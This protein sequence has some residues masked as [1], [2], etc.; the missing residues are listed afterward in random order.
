MMREMSD[1]IQDLAMA[2]GERNT[3][4][5]CSVFLSNLK[6]TGNKKVMDIVFRVFA[7][8]ILKRDLGFYLVNGAV[9]RGAAKNMIELQNVLIKDMASNVD[10]LIGSLN[11]PIDQLHV[12]IATDFEKYYASENFGEV[13]NARM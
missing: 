12:P 8:D 13:T 11:V 5:A 9:S 6:N 4:E 3:I 1:T 10:S 7:I 2:Y